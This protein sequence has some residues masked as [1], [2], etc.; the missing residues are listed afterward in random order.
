MTPMTE[1]TRRALYQH[2]ANLKAQKKMPGPLKAFESVLEEHLEALRKEHENLVM[3]SAATQNNVDV[4]R[5][6]YENQKTLTR[7]A[8]VYDRE[9]WDELYQ[10]RNQVEEL[11]Y[12]GELAHDKLQEATAKLVS[13]E[14]CIE[15]LR[16]VILDSKASIASLQSRMEHL[17]FGRNQQQ[18]ESYREITALASL[19]K[20]Q[21]KAIESLTFELVSARNKAKKPSFWR[22]LWQKKAQ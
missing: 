8:C 2:L 17:S 13:R 16:L 19:V 3:I 5:D 18:A 4:Y 11:K 15:G 7:N 14:E 21:R 9:R 12:N 6:A 10:L 22:F 20:R 1:T